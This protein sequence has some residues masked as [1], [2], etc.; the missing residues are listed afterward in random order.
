MPC[1]PGLVLT[2]LAG[3]AGLLTGLIIGLV[4]LVVALIDGY[5]TTMFRTHGVKLTA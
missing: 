4:D 3:A 5:V 1:N 2:P